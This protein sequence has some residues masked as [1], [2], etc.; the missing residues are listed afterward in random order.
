VC[1]VDTEPP[2]PAGSE[3]GRYVVAVLD[4]DTIARGYPTDHPFTTAEVRQDYAAATHGLYCRDLRHGW[5]P[6]ATG[7]LGATSAFLFSVVYWNLEGQPARMDAD[8]DGIP[9]ETLYE[10][11]VIEAL[12]LDI[13]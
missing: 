8:G 9:C 1:S 12:L 7:E 13:P 10:P 5:P 3:W 2:E 6:T 11:T 4:E